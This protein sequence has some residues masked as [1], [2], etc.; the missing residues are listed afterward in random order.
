MHQATS[1]TQVSAIII[2]IEIGDI[3]CKLV[4]GWAQADAGGLDFYTCLCTAN[5]TG[6][7]P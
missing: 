3:F 4:S 2:F 1:I 7:G 6:L 5:I